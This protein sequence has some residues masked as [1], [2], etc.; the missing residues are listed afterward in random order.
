MPRPNLRVLPPAAQIMIDGDKKPEDMVW[1]KDRKRLYASYGDELHVQVNPGEP[2]RVVHLFKDK[3]AKLGD[4]FI[5]DQGVEIL[6]VTIAG[7]ENPSG[8]S[9]QSNRLRFF[10]LAPLKQCLRDV[11]HRTASLVM[12]DMGWREIDGLCIGFDIQ[13][14]QIMLQT[15]EKDKRIR[16]EDADDYWIAVMAGPEIDE[17]DAK[18]APKRT[19]RSLPSVERKRRR[20]LTLA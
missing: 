7:R 20:S 4:T 2:F 5:N 14:R 15:S 6:P 18:P 10:E 16:K 12:R 19:V 17:E 1:S 11:F 9:R 13:N 8:H 3:I